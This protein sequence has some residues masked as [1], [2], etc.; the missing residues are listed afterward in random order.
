MDPHPRQTPSRCRLS[1]TSDG[2]LCG[3]REAENMGGRSETANG[4]RFCA[5]LEKDENDVISLRRLDRRVGGRRRVF[6][7]LLAARLNAGPSHAF[8]IEIAAVSDDGG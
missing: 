4:Y 7:Q 3:L 2:L 8:G 5:V 6:R 1:E